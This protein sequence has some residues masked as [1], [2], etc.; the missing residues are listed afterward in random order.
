LRRVELEDIVDPLLKIPSSATEDVPEVP[1][2]EEE[3]ADNED[4]AELAR[5]TERGSARI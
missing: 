3:G 2:T 4:Y 1:S 5:K